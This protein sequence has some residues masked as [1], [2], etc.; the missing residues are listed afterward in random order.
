MRIK[1]R[2]VDSLGGIFF[3]RALEQID[4]LGVAAVQNQRR[5]L[6]RRGQ[7]VALLLDVCFDGGERLSLGGLSGEPGEQEGPEGPK[8]G[9]GVV[10]LREHLGGHEVGRADARE[11]G[12]GWAGEAS[13]AEIGDLEEGRVGAGGGDQQILGLE[14]A[15]DDPL[16]VQRRETVREVHG[17]APGVGA[18][19]PPSGLQALQARSVAPAQLGDEADVA[20]AAEDGGELDDVRGLGGGTAK[21]VDFGSHAR[22]GGGIVRE[23]GE[24]D[25]LDRDIGL[26][27]MGDILGT[28]HLT[29]RAR[30]NQSITIPISN[31]KT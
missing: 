9:A 14:V 13:E 17:E 31:S 6:D 23:G 29:K 25:L 27:L 16:V 20:G 2:Q 1:F 3:Q 12:G 24:A 8:I 19:E 15:V 28:I 7:R 21:E 30:S 26:I 5:Q 22:E 18:S 4:E 10:D 11:Q